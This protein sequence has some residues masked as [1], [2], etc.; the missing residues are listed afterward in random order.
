MFQKSYVVSQDEFMNIGFVNK[1][2]F[3][4]Q[5]ISYSGDI[6]T[7]RLKTANQTLAFYQLELSSD[8]LEYGR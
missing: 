2:N 1:Y 8:R 4:T 3:T 6:Q 7:K 5:E